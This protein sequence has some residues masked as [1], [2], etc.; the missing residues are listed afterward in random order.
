MKPVIRW[1]VFGLWG[2]LVVVRS[3][4]QLH[5]AC[6]T[7]HTIHGSNLDIKCNNTDDIV[8]VRK[9][10]SI[11]SLGEN[12]TSTVMKNG[13]CQN[14]SS[15][16]CFLSMTSDIP[17]AYT[18]KISL[19]CNGNHSCTLGEGDLRPSV[20]K[21]KSLCQCCKYHVYRIRIG[22]FF[23]CLP[24]K[25]QVSVGKN[26]T[27]TR[28]G[29]LYLTSLESGRCLIRGSIESA[30]ILE[31]SNIRF[32]VSDG[33]S[34][35]CTE[36]L[37]NG[38]FNYNKDLSCLRGLDVF[39]LDIQTMDTWPSKL[40]MEFKGT[41]MQ[42]D[43]GNNIQFPSVVRE[44]QDPEQNGASTLLPIIIGLV[45]GLLLL[46]VLI[47]VILKRKHALTIKAEAKHCTINATTTLEGDEDCTYY[48]NEVDKPRNDANDAHV[49]GTSS[50]FDDSLYNTIDT[51]GNYSQI[52]IKK[53]TS[54]SGGRSGEQNLKNGEDDTE[55]SRDE[56]R[57]TNNVTTRSSNT[58]EIKPNTIIGEVT[59]DV[60]AAV[61]KTD[62]LKSMRITGPKGDIYA[63]VSMASNV[64]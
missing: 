41:S 13:E 14:T 31:Q 33:K 42:L 8:Y 28:D 63:T 56:S 26:I 48:N 17:T 51:G 19:Y 23:E 44:V 30:R 61:C 54:E 25:S 20:D 35:L 18:S 40:W 12:S 27:E 7:L 62:D 45:A 49:Q 32:T 34:R 55:K 1:I 57:D 58:T 2:W 21:F 64:E 6:R 10:L 5:T 47:L 36:V 60:Y 4:Q 24:S 59:G 39:L 46:L 22:A 3:N 29:S 37:T 11:N 43:C 16:T 38:S 15:S 52:N 9:Q 50:T 53:N